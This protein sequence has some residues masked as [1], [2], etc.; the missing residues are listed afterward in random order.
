MAHLYCKCFTVP[1]ACPEFSAAKSSIDRYSRR[2][3]AEAPQ[4]FRHQ[5]PTIALKQHFLTVDLTVKLAR[6]GTELPVFKCLRVL[7][8]IEWE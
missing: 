1:E 4:P 7:E 2:M 3:A 6:P 8:T 5:S